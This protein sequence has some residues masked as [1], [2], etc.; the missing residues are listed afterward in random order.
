MCRNTQPCVDLFD[1]HVFM[2]WKLCGRSVLILCLEIY[3]VGTGLCF[4]E[5]SEGLLDYIMTVEA[6]AER[7]CRLVVQAGH[8]LN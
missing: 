5:D 8:H 3:N 6:G 2:V 7:V 1:A 4:V